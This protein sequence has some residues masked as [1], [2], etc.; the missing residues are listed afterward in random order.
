MSGISDVQPRTV[1]SILLRAHQDKWILCV[2]CTYHLKLFLA[3]ST[4]AGMKS[5]IFCVISSCKAEPRTLTF[6]NP[7]PS[8]T[9]WR[10]FVDQQEF[11]CMWCRG[12]DGK[13]GQ[14]I[15]IGR[16]MNSDGKPPAK[17]WD[18]WSFC[19][20]LWSAGSWNDSLCPVTLAP[21][22]HLSPPRVFKPRFV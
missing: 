18:T 17:I 3:V 9:Q 12:T 19:R 5:E 10:Y 21:C 20:V 16:R 22:S 2:S 11:R 8:R 14:T 6:K 1:L 13:K 15:A 4:V 7:T